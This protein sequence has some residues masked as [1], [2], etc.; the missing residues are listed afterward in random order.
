MDKITIKLKVS[1]EWHGEIRLTPA[2]KKKSGGDLFACHGTVEK[3]VPKNLYKLIKSGCEAEM[4]VS[5]VPMDYTIMVKIRGARLYGVDVC[6]DMD[7]SKFPKLVDFAKGHTEP[8]YV[9]FEIL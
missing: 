5:K 2:N 4:T 3:L 1:I 6:W 8:F 9:L 7:I